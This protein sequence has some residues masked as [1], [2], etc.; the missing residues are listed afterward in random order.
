[1]DNKEILY[2]Y[3][4]IN[5]NLDKEEI[6]SRLETVLGYLRSL[7]KKVAPKEL[8]E[9]FT[10]QWTFKTEISSKNE[11]YCYLRA[12]IYSSTDSFQRVI[13]QIKNSEISE[14]KSRLLKDF[15]CD[16]KPFISYFDKD[17]DY[18]WLLLNTNTHI[19][20]FYLNLANNSFWN[21]QP[22]EHPEERLALSTST[23][24]IIRQVIEYK[25]KRILAIDYLTKGKKPFNRTP[26]ICFKILDRCSKLLKLNN[27][28]FEI[29]KNIYSWTHAYIHGGYRAE[30][31]K[32]ESVLDYLGN[33]YYSG[34]TSKKNSFSKYAGVEVIESN[35]PELKLL[36]EQVCKKND[37][38]IK[39]LIQNEVAI[40]K[41]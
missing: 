9:S 30:P 38:E 22:S 2:A 25:I 8:K 35:L 19:S 18:S 39:W 31:W 10:Y 7:R 29:I 1:M 33:V 37:L 14:L 16:L 17:Q 5:K 32:T 28:S 41:E 13:E 23:P 34:E 26:D 11:Y 6:I 40:I 36:T 4:A 3:Q 15:L 27:F 24:F 21:G 12:N 20:N